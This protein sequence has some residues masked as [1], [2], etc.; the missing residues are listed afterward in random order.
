MAEREEEPEGIAGVIRC[1]KNFF[2]GPNMAQRAREKR[3]LAFNRRQE[4]G[5]SA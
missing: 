3:P 2:S 4:Q 5:T 1:E